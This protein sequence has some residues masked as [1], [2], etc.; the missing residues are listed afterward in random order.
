MNNHIG[1]SFSESVIFLSTAKGETI[2]N[3]K[4]INYL[5]PFGFDRL[6]SEKSLSF[7]AEQIKKAKEQENASTLSVVLPLNYTHFK[8]VALP[9]ES[10]KDLA[11]IQVEWEFKNY[12]S[13]QLSEYKIINTKT[14][15]RFAGYREW[16]FLAIKKSI[17][18]T[19]SL[20]ASQNGLQLRR[21]V[22]VN[23]VV[24]QCLPK[25]GNPTLVFKVAAAHLETF[26]FVN[27]S[28]YDSYLDAVSTKQSVAEICKK[29]YMD[30]QVTLERFTTLNGDTLECFVYGEGLNPEI[31]KQ[32][33][34]DFSC[35]VNRLRSGFKED[36]ETG[37]EAAE[38]LLGN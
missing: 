20:L 17:L 24:E 10:E 32:I 9:M 19:F 26:M 18:E 16:L 27:G 3:V 14:E 15:F 25:S 30:A 22:P 38:V 5:S 37:L 4:R 12:L 33:A 21:V 35:P 7:L 36:S 13:G 23:Q 29:R 34:A 2:Q 28:F 6:L 1:I 11:Q 31:E 8:R